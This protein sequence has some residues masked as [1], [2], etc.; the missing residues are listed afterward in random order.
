[1]SSTPDSLAQRYGRPS[2]TSRLIV[3]VVVGLIVIALVA[4]LVWAISGN[5]DP[6]VSS[7]EG[8][9]GHGTH[10]A[11][12]EYQVMYGDGPV[13]ATCTARALASDGEEVGRT[14]VTP[15]RDP[16]SG[17]LYRITF[18]TTREAASVEW[19]GCTA[20]GQPRPR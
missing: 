18:K 3:A 15:P 6:A 16:R 1:M 8:P 12:I 4:W 19:L 17:Q 20:P 14:T 5:S 10:E 13:D 11:W 9:K 2:G 7:Q